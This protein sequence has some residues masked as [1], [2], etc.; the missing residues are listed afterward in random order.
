MRLMAL[1]PRARAASCVFCAALFTLASHVLTSATPR[2]SPQQDR[3]TYPTTA[4]SPTSA[5]G[6]GAAETAAAI[7]LWREAGER[8][9]TGVYGTWADCQREVQGFSNMRF[10]TSENAKAF[11]RGEATTA[12]CSAGGLDGQPVQVCWLTP[13]VAWYLPFGQMW[14]VG[15]LP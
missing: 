4:R 8:E 15:T 5:P 2:I 7:T 14:H 9:C 3:S 12:T 10:K 1:L 13:Q 6:C 11:A